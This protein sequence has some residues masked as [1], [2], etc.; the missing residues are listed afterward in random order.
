META[1]ASTP[2][3]VTAAGHTFYLDPQS[4]DVAAVAAHV[5]SMRHGPPD[6]IIRTGGEMRIS[7]FML[8]GAAY[9]ELF[10][11]ERLWP[12]FAE[13]DLFEAIASYQRRE[14][15]FGGLGAGSKHTPEG[16]TST[17]S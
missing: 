11:S 10:F 14:R 16:S 2:V 9:A 6:L 7:P 12:D 17:R 15:R 8:F 1:L 5:P 3:P 13:A 4:I